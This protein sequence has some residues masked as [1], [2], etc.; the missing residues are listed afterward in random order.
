MCQLWSVQEKETQT[1]DGR[2]Y[3]PPFSGRTV[4]SPS[5]SNCRL[6]SDRGRYFYLCQGTETRL[7]AQVLTM[8]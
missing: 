8:K 3:S 2:S 1:L 4:V 7:V 6:V 5:A